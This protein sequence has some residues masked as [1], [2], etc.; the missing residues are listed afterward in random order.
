MISSTRS[1]E[2]ASRSSWNEA[3][4]LISF[5][6][7]PSCSTSTSLTLSATSSREAAISFSY[8]PFSLGP[9]GT[10]DATTLTR[11][12][13]NLFFEPCGDALDHVSGR[14]LGPEGDRV[15]DRRARAIPVRD[16]RE[17]AQS[18]EVRAAVGVRVESLSQ[19]ARC[20]TDEETA[21]LPA[22]A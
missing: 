19:T 9:G 7:T 10:A 16:D 4:S 18:E 2:S 15:G 12:R 1:S 5:A 14:A 11:C 20:G 6:S 17:A 13:R 22:R 3:S 21:Q 8:L